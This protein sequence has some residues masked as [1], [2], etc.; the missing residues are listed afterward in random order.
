MSH[1]IVAAASLLF[2]IGL[3]VAFVFARGDVERLLA[4]HQER[5]QEE[6]APALARIE[7]ARVAIEERNEPVD[8]DKTVRVLHEIDFAMERASS[9]E[10]YVDLVAG[11]DYR[12]V[13][14]R[15]LAMRKE[16]MDVLFE[17]YSKRAQAAEQEATWGFARRWLAPLTL[18]D[19]VKIDGALVTGIFS[20]TPSLGVDT[21]KSIEEYRAQLSNLDALQRDLE[22]LQRRAVEVAVN[23]SD[24][25]WE[26]LEDWDRLCLLRDR[27]YLAT[28]SGDWESARARADEAIAAAPLEKEAHLLKALALIEGE[29]PW[30][31]ESGEVTRLLREFVQR[32]PESSAPA[33]L[34]E[35]VYEAKRGNV[36]EARLLLQQSATSYPR[37]AEALTELLDPYQV[38]SRYLRKSREGNAIR[39][40]YRATMLGASWFSPDLQLARLDFDAGDRAAGE[41]KIMDHFARRRSQ[42]QWDL[43]LYD[44][45]FCEDL[46]G[47]D[48]RRIFPEDID[49][50]L[51]IDKTFFGNKYALSVENKSE[52]TLHNATLVLCLQFTD[53]HPDDYETF[54][55]ETA[56]EVPAGTTTDFGEVEIGM[57]LFGAEKTRSDVYSARAVLVAN[58]AVVWVDT[59]DFKESRALDRA[60]ERREGAAAALDRA[61][62][63][64]GDLVQ[65]ALDLAD[66]DIGLEIVPKRLFADDVI[67]RLPKRIAVLRPAFRLHHGD[68][69]YAPAGNEIVNGAIEL[70]FDGVS[71]FEPEAGPLA[72][73]VES[74][75]ATVVVHWRQT[76]PDAYAF[77]RIALGTD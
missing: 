55:A 13:D 75:L 22:G 20:R 71:E 73:H 44:L 5:V 77:E 33:L 9:V 50:D 4:A 53:M 26:V 52:R 66:Q 47:D 29:F 11:Q 63:L 48:Y 46:L 58:E 54:A 28:H 7:E 12:N 27:A 14:P 51:V 3:I 24:A 18:T 41:R 62:G 17:L 37:Q 25:T 56:P 64:A 67:V 32:H 65:A 40:L 10:E 60:R 59:I 39:E 49:L 15:I 69:V 1:R 34:L 21:R 8:L 38:R 30:A 31:E 45:V 36:E 43:I 2:L 76:G 6:F 16:V 74:G 61:K 42:G 23:H 57:Q 70:R 72:L 68:E 35:G 19:S